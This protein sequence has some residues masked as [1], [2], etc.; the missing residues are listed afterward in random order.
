MS[1]EGGDLLRFQR[2]GVERGDQ[3]RHVL[4]ILLRASRGR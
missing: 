4:P 3:H 2:G 1:P